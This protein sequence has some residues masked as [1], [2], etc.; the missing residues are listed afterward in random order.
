V[1]FYGRKKVTKSKFTV[2]FVPDTQ[3][4]TAE[5]QGKNGGNNSMYKAQTQWIATNRAA[6]NIRFVA[7]LGDCSERGDTYEVEWKRVDTA[8]R[9]IENASLTG[10][11][12]G[13]PYTLT[14]GNH[15]QSANGDPKG[16][17]N[18]Y[19]KY[20]GASRYN[21]KSYYG[22]HNGTN[23]DNHYALFSASGT[24]FLVISPE[25]DQTTGFTASGGALDWMESIV[26]LYP[27][28]KVIVV[29][30]FVMDLTATFS[31]QGAA[32][33]NRLKVYPNFILLVGAHVT[34][35]GEVRRSDT[36][37]GNVVHTVVQ[38]YQA[39]INGGNGLMRTYEFDP[40]N[41]SVFVQTFSPYANISETD[42]GSQFTLNVNLATTPDAYALIGEVS[43]VAS[44]TNACVNWPSL[45]DNTTYEWYAEVSDGKTTTTGPVWSFTTKS[46][47]TTSIMSA[48][49]PLAL[50]KEQEAS[51]SESG[52]AIYPNPNNIHH[53]TLSLSSEI[54]GRVQVE[55]RD[56]MGKVVLQRDFKEV[57]NTMQLDH[58]LAAGT[59]VVVLKTSTTRLTRKL[60]V[61]E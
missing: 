5:P 42:A 59:Y 3:F 35:D 43:N 14:V 38:N 9:T 12:E 7:G 49:Q 24:D 18:F 1:R 51:D 47:S 57:S 56:M 26:K 19:N 31:A 23:N 34:G 30:H 32:I 39:R 20:F 41:N 6:K 25:Y 29:S 40:L 53:L 58:Q 15:D 50:I 2:A 46:V 28:R 16:T 21:G 13:I 33:Y 22:G 55:I 11:A 44:G 52:F 37:N 54:K 45:L 8:V 48:N 60:V 36:Y 27:S 61:V 17:T 10:L 4:Y